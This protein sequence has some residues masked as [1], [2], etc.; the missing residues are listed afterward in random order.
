MDVFVI[1]VGRE[2]YELYCEP[3][4]ADVISDADAPPGW[5]GRLR[6][7]FTDMLRATEERPWP[8]IPRTCRS[9]K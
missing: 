1:P 3:S 2:H 9:I 6:Q 8:S 4:A 5:I 7:R